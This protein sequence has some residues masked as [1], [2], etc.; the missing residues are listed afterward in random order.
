MFLAL[1]PDHTGN[2]FLARRLVVPGCYFF[3]KVT[4]RAA[5]GGEAARMRVCDATEFPCLEFRGLEVSFAALFGF[6]PNEF[7]EVGI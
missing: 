1:G 2:E 5:H 3:S 4:A 6:E 7:C